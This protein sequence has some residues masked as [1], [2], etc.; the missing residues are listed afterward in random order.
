MDGAYMEVNRFSIGKAVMSAGTGRPSD[1]DDDTVDHLSTFGVV[2]QGVPAMWI[3]GG[4]P[5]FRNGQIEG[6]SG[7]GGALQPNRRSTRASAIK[8]PPIQRGYKPPQAAV[9]GEMAH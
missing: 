3:R 1:E 5:V 8:P 6:A 7:V 2:V 4:L 9:V